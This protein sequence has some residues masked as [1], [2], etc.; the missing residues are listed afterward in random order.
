MAVFAAVLCIAGCGRKGELIVPGTVLPA[1]VSDLSAEPRGDAVILS[2]GIP[3]KTTGATQLTNLAGFDIFRAELAPEIAECPCQ[4]ER[5]ATV[6]VAGGQASGA[7]ITDN[8][9]VWVDADPRLKVN[10]KYAY[11]VAAVNTDNFSG[12]QSK[13]VYAVLLSLPAAPRNL[14]AQPADK[15]AKLAWDAV[16]A[17]TQNAPLIDIAGYNIYRSDKEGGKPDRKV[18][19]EPVKEASLRDSGLEN[20]RK[21][22]Y[23]VAAVRGPQ[24]PLTEGAR[25]E[26]ATVVPADVEA[27]AAPTGLRAVPGD[28][29]V[30]LSWDPNVEPDLKGYFV[31]RKAGGDTEFRKLNEAPTDKITFRDNAVEKGREYSYALTAVDSS[32]PPNESGRS[33]PVTVTLVPSP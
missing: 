23:S 19:A 32:T 4:F 33:A 9:A 6:P 1:A 11:K 12:P 5:V 3:Q 18:N 2:F 25:S 8:R 17:T 7:V 16:D 29:F 15:T 24:K 28:G 27:P 20:G 13:P 21:Y 10:M 31:F 14:T 22:W 30:A 26:T